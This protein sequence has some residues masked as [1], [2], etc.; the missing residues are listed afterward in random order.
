[1]RIDLGDYSL[2]DVGKKDSASQRVPPEFP[3]ERTR[4]RWN[5]G[6]VTAGPDRSCRSIGCSA[7]PA[8]EP[9]AGLNER[10]QGEAHRGSSVQI[11]VPTQV[12]YGME[13]SQGEVL[14]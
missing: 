10:A 7:D 1:M 13:Y 12:P 5:D 9:S 3:R 11:F 4:K 2:A 14:W 8:Q 6:R